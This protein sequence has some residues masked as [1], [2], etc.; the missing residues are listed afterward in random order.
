LGG[1]LASNSKNESAWEHYGKNDPYFGVLTADTYHLKILDAEA[2]GQF[3]G[4]GTRYVNGLMTALRDLAGPSFA[5]SRVLDFGCGVGRLTIPLSLCC[6]EAV[7]VDISDGMLAEAA[8]NAEEQQ[9][10]NVSWVKADETLSRVTG[11]FD[12]IHS[13]IVFQHI[14]KEHGL[15]M[16]RKLISLLR[17]G[18]AGS[19]QFTYANSSTT[20][21]WRELASQSYHRFKLAY[22]VRNLIRGR[23]FFEPMMQMNLYDV[24]EILR[25]LHETGCHKVSLRLTETSHFGFPVYGAAFIF[26]KQ[27]L[28]VSEH[29]A[30]APD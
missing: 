8:R 16:L 12:L 29:G 18:G 25:I 30:M 19:L 17:E 13:F 21:R 26:Q 23:P 2:K 4:S 1:P 27:R 6:T 11:S 20:P 5:P 3:F 15:V 28:D 7:G 14:A 9:L 24:N 22:G 10:T